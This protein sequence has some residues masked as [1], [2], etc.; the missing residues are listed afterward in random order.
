MRI[1]LN[2]LILL[3]ISTNVCAE[4]YTKYFGRFDSIPVTIITKSKKSKQEY[5]S[6]RNRRRSAPYG[7]EVPGQ[8]TLRVS[9]SYYKEYE[10]IVISYSHFPEY[11]TGWVS[12]TEAYRQPIHNERIDAKGSS[13]QMT[14]KGLP[15]GNYKVYGFAVW[16]RN[17]KKCTN[18]V[19]FKVR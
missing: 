18:T 15:K 9:K 16:R 2:I 7:F 6:I 13:G 5:I 11:S 4:V 1:K 10:P 17:K 8:A 14:F 12:I 19:Y 3:F